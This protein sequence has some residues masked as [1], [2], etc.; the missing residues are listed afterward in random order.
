MNHTQARNLANQLWL[1][2]E[3]PTPDPGPF[4][5]IWDKLGGVIIWGATIGGL[6]ALIWAGVMLGWEK[7]DP[8][9][10][11][12]SGSAILWTI[13]GGI[14]AAGGAQIINWTYGT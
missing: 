9:R 5:E 14:V 2:I 3:Q 4:G 10:E 11:Q 8:S 1:A 13:V 12:K 7:L 6:G